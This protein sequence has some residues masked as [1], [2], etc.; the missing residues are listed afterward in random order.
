MFSKDKL[1]KYGSLIRDIV[2]SAV[3]SKSIDAYDIM[4]KML[5]ITSEVDFEVI[6][7]LIVTLENSGVKIINKSILS[8]EFTQPTVAIFD[9]SEEETAISE[10]NS[11][12]E[13]NSYIG[14]ALSLLLRD[15][16]RFPVLSEEESY[17]LELAAYKGDVNAR[18]K[19]ICSNIKLV[20]SIAKRYQNRGLDL[21]DL[22]QEGCIG[23]IIAI[24]KFEP[25]RGYR[26]STMA[27]WW[28]KQ[29]ISRALAD[30]GKIIR[31][32]VHVFDA[33]NK[34][35]ININKFESTFGHS[36][37]VS[38]LAE[39]IGVDTQ[40]ISYWLKLMA[41]Y[42][43]G[44]VSLETPVGEDG[45]TSLSELLPSDELC[46]EDVFESKELRSQITDLLDTLTH[47]EEKIMTLRYGI[48]DNR[49]RTLE[50]V[51]KE[52]NVTR[53]RIRQIEAKALRKL[54]HPT[55]S[56]KLKPYYY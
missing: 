39:M 29:N 32:P 48:D 30:K 55:R 47:R 51:G 16:K 40:R 5:D 20:V 10:T 50:E 43:S 54:R 15:T 26:L 28:I 31:L 36:P 56:K 42:D 25:Y 2:H 8:E 37:S 1:N 4:D 33:L 45:D 27:T 35:K 7:E 23:L 41:H 34:V 3:V 12:Y 13:D 11:D 49:H 17:E 22:V 19:L 6:G 14:D 38:E 21:A 24:D 18:L 44:F 9:G 46:P 53:E 52:F